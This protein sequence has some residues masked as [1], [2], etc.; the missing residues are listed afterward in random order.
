M[1]DT[2]YVVDD[3]HHLGRTRRLVQCR[4]ETRPQMP[5]PQVV[6]VPRPL[7]HELVDFAG[8]DLLHIAAADEGPGSCAL[9]STLSGIWG[10]RPPARRAGSWAGMTITRCIAPRPCRVHDHSRSSAGLL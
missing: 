8:E 4:V 5:D 1:M 2:A 6:A 9:A 3:L 7:P 10:D